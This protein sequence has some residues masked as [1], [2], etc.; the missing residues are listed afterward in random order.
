MEEN[1]QVIDETLNQ[2]DGLELNHSSLRFLNETRKWAKFLS[3][4]MFTVTGI[5]ILFSFSVFMLGSSLSETNEF[6]AP[7]A[8]GGPGFMI[9]VIIMSALYFIPAYFL[10]QFSNNMKQAISEQNSQKLEISFRYLKSHYKFIGILAIV[11][12]GIYLILALIGVIAMTF[13]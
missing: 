10:L 6:F 2:S 9:V 12:I 1:Y 11:I 3:I 4:L 8:A 7:Y 5:M 13:A